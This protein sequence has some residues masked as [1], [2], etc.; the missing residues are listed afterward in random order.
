MQALGNDFLVLDNLPSELN[1]SD[2]QALA[3]RKTGVGFDQLLS[4]KPNHQDV[5][6]LE[7]F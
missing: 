7:I 2:I 3:C 1:A 6:T 5:A 4:I